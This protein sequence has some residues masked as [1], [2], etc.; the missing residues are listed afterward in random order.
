MVAR[1]EVDPHEPV[2]SDMR[3]RVKFHILVRQDRDKQNKIGLAR[4]LPFV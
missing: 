3:T 4:G 2:A 1:S